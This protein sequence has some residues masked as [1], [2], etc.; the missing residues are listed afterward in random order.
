[1]IGAVVL[2]ATVITAP[3]TAH[4]GRSQL[5]HLSEGVQQRLEQRHPKE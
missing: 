2:W 5:G 4:P 1:M 3:P